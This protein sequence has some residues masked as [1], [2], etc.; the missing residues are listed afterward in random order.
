MGTG[1]APSWEDG[2]MS[3][4]REHT[5][6]PACRREVWVSAVTVTNDMTYFPCR[7]E[8]RQGEVAFYPG[9]EGK[10]DCSQ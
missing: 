8:R 2:Y 9:L 1:L 7:G 10:K 3:S 5:E 4:V 6:R